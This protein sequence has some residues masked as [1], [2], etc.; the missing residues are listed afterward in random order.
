MKTDD[1]NFDLPS[2]LIAQ[3]PPEKRGESRL[4]VLDRETGEIRHSKVG[5]IASF[6]EPG[7]LM[8][9]NDSRVRKARIYG[10]SLDTEAKVEFLLLSR[11]SGDTWEA[12]CTKLRKQREGRRYDFGEGV[13]GEI[14]A[15]GRSRYD[16]GSA[17]SAESDSTRH[18]RFS[19]P[20]DEAWLEAHG[21]IPLP[22]YIRREDA[23]SDAER[24]QTIFARQVGSAAAPT[25]GLHF[26]EEILGRLRDAGIETATLTLHVGLGT[27][28][29]VR[30]EEIE[31][32]VMHEEWW[33]LST[34]TAASVNRAKLEGRPV[35]AIGTTSVRTLESAWKPADDEG[36]A[37]LRA[38]EGRTRI[39]ITPGYEWKLVDRLFT[40]FHT[41]RSTLLMLVAAFAGR[42]R[43]LSAYASAVEQ[44]YRFFSYGDAMLIR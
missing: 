25:A 3:H 34:E 43:I 29:P 11:I 10:T 1:F 8:V 13:F 15:E 33:S 27:F 32:H 35:L 17:R 41:P 5:D 2:E 6:L 42:D 30:G 7:T 14:V 26:T 22:P 23:P 38:G 18:L 12:S 20:I 28:L 40:N 31:D 19:P 36:P 4:L 9:M 21:H 16:L 44:R 39:F 24:Y 37:G